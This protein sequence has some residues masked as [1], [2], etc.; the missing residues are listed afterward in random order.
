MT[1]TVF[2]AWQDPQKRLWYPIG[3]LTSDGRIFRFAYTRGASSACAANRFVPLAAFPDLHR[4]Y[5]S[6]RLFPLF[7]NRLL[8][9]SRPEFAQFLRWLN[10]EDPQPAPLA[11]LARSGG[12]RETDNLEVFPC[13]EPAIDGMYETAFFLRGLR[14]MAQV[15]VERAGRLEAGE[16]LCVMLDLENDFDRDAMALRAADRE[17]PLL[18]GYLPRYLSGELVRLMRTTHRTPDVTVS[19]VNADA[20]LQF[21]VLCQLRIQW[22]EGF[23]PFS[24]EEYQP[25][26]KLETA[27]WVTGDHS[28]TV[29]V[30]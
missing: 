19:Q 1:R 16:R 7:A 15:A 6:E 27:D 24:G 13:P 17:S 21:R 4:V 28:L 3:K 20:P 10:L 9:T 18:L 26:T 5:E 12:A 14:H 29:V 2:L 25:L 30:P 11:L 8:P 22:G 23:R